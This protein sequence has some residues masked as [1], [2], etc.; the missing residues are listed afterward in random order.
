MPRIQ[1]IEDVRIDYEAFPEET[2]PELIREWVADEY[3]QG[4]PLAIETESGEIVLREGT[5]Q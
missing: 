4:Q 1:N 5:K 2:D 3:E